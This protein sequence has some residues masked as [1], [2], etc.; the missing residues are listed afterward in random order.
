MRS[1]RASS[2]EPLLLSSKRKP[3]R[4]PRLSMKLRNGGA[5][6]MT[7]SRALVW[8]RIYWP[9]PLPVDHAAELI[10]RLAADA[11]RGTVIFEA[12]SH[13]G[14]VAHFFAGEAREIRQLTQLVEAVP[15]TVTTS[16]KTER[17]LA[18]TA[19]MTLS[20]SNLPL[21]DR[22]A[23]E[24][25]RHVLGALATA[26][27]SDESVALRVVI[28]A[29]TSPRLLQPRPADPSQSWSSRLTVGIRPASGEIA[30]RL[31]AKEQE[32]H[33]RIQVLAGA[34]AKSEGRR[35]AILTALLSAFRTVEAAGTKLGFSATPRSGRTLRSWLDLTAVEVLNFLGFPLDDEDLPGMPPS[36]PK[37]LRLLAKDI[38]T[39]RVFATTSAPGEKRPIGIS[40]EDSRVHM[41]ILGPTN[42][43]KSTL[44]HRLIA[45][46]IA[47]GRSVVVIDAKTDLVRSVLGS[48]VDSRYDDVVLLDA[49]LDKP[50]GLNILASSLIPPELMADNLLG[51]IRDLF[52]SAFGPRT[53]DAVHSALLTIAGYPGATLA[54]LP[55]LFDDNRLRRRVLSAQN[56]AFGLNSF[57]DYYDGLSDGARS[58]LVGPVLSRLRQFMLRPSLRKVLDQSHPKFQLED[59][60]S[61]RPRVL[62]VPLNAGTLG[63][64]ASTILG[65]LIV[66]GIT[67][68]TLAQATVPANER[69]P[70]SIFIDEAQTYVSNSGD[71]L[72][73]SLEVSRGL[74][75]SWHVAHQSRSQMSRDIL[76]ALDANALNKVAFRLGIDDAKAMA[77]MAPNLTSEDFL[78]L[79]RFGIYGSITRKGETLGWI[80]GTTLPPVKPISDPDWIANHSA[81]LYG[82]EPSEITVTVLPQDNPKKIGSRPRRQP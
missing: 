9:T 21:L 34:Q 14:E 1:M 15:G 44:M 23:A 10:R 50:P 61:A 38:E 33:L 16:E 42:S 49:T 30:N 5:G 65:K 52:P 59:L 3:S 70:V 17:A 53:S 72:A 26:M 78:A 27:Y 6:Q 71:S 51:L 55:K 45:H 22:R 47:A 8:R 63:T 57:W 24:S 29:R 36:H 25:S 35:R 60:F 48:I 2:P 46:D 81:L 19:R 73:R 7:S 80:S 28:G 54:W 67:Q 66:S 31:R 76:S 43:S 37:A 62:L 74:N 79:P 39:E 64:E 68:L 77:A 13:E 40:S 58:Q 11:L 75:C 18:F 56:D 69:R 20:G 32:A 41:H 82:G 12:V 4:K